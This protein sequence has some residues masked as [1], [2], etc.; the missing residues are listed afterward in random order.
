MADIEPAFPTEAT[1]TPAPP[2]KRKLSS[3]VMIW[4]FASHYPA[5]LLIALAALLTT[6]AATLYIPWSIKSVIDQGFTHGSTDA[7]HIDTIFYGLFA[8]VGVLAIATALRNSG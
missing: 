8:V 5:Q 2:E 3:L 4:R 7:H 6:S 1:P